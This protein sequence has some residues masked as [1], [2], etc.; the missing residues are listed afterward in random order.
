MVSLKALPLK[1]AIAATIA[2][3]SVMAVAAPADAWCGRY[4]RC[5]HRYYRPYGYYYGYTPYYGYRY[6]YRRHYGYYWSRPYHR[7][8]WHYW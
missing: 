2:A 4:H 5:Y 7:R 3:S 6:G 1:T 8:Y